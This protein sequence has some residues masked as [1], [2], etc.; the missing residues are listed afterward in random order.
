MGTVTDGDT[1]LF[2]QHI[3]FDQKLERFIEQMVVYIEKEELYSQSREELK[4]YFCPD[5]S[6][7]VVAG[8]LKKL[9]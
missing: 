5:V 7:E 6:S 1:T 2:E 4:S 8:Y 9:I 3:V